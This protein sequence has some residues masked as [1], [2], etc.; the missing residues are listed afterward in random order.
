MFGLFIY[1]MAKFLTSGYPSIARNLQIV[2]LIVDAKLFWSS[3]SCCVS[4][5]L[6]MVIFGRR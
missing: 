3:N 2:C 6:L 1:C 4:V 5:D